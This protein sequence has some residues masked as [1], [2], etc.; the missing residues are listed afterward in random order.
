[1]GD[2]PAVA[3]DDVAQ[4]R[5]AFCVPAPQRAE[6]QADTG[7]VVV[8]TRPWWAPERDMCSRLDATAV[9]KKIVRKV[10]QGLNERIGGRRPVEAG[11]SPIRMEEDWFPANRR[12]PARRIAAELCGI[13]SATVG[14]YWKVMQDN[15]GVLTAAES[16][17]PQ[18][19]H[20]ED[21]SIKGFAPHEG[22][23]RDAL[24]KRI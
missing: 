13:A 11:E 10:Y 7:H 23:Q 14:K 3:T 1:M 15:Q 16:R 17:G 12:R 19:K 24:K 2:A 22:T 18:R 21:L 9:A 5:V 4:G 6:A 20:A 8:E